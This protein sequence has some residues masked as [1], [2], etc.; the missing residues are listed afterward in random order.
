M[1][2]HQLDDDSNVVAVVFDRDDSHD[3]GSIFCVGIL[4]IFV[5]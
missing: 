4:A 2:L 3:V 5:S 1:V